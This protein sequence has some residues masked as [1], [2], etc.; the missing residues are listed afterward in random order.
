MDIET[1]TPNPITT[2]QLTVILVVVGSLVLVPL[3]IIAVTKICCG[4][5]N[6]W[7]DYKQN[8]RR[9]RHHSVSTTASSSG[10]SKTS[11]MYLEEKLAL[12]E[13]HS[14]LVR[15]TG[16]RLDDYPFI[17]DYRPAPIAAIGLPGFGVGGMGYRQRSHSEMSSDSDSHSS[18]VV[19]G[20]T[21]HSE[22]TTNS[23]DGSESSQP[24]PHLPSAAAATTNQND[25]IVLL[26]QEGNIMFH[27]V[28]KERIGFVMILV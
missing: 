8:K 9:R 17:V 15:E 21:V 1:T 11:S 13:G 24:S 26:D 18:S 28:H 14:R 6:I 16:I 4:F 19:T 23:I 12:V 27:L 22:G 20:A 3:A 7:D 5:I 10:R 2:T 25:C